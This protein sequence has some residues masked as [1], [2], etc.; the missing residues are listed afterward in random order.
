MKLLPEAL[1][2]DDVLLVP[3]ESSVLPSQTDVSTQLAPNIKLN[4]PIISAAMDTVTTAPLAISL[5]LQGGLGIIHKNMSIE[6]Q[7]DMVDRVKRSENG[8]IANRYSNP[9]SKARM[10]YLVSIVSVFRLRTRTIQSRAKMMIT[11]KN[12]T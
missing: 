10:A 5:A 9:M 3:A 2:F 4:I 12:L 11:R 7:A 1:T 8:V 6:A